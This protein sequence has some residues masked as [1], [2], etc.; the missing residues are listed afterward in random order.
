MKTYVDGAVKQG[1]AVID[2]NLPKHISDSDSDS[3][4]Y[5]E[6]D[7]VEARI[8]QATQLLTYLWENYIE[9]NENTHVFLLGTNT[10]HGAIVNFI[11]NHE[12]R[13]RQLITKAI[14]LVEDVGL[15]S[16]KSLVGN[17][18]LAQWYWTN[19]LVF[20]AQDHNYF[21]SDLARKPKKRFG[22]I[23][24]SQA[25]S[26]SDMLLEHREK[27]FESLLEETE[28]WRSNQTE[29]APTSLPNA[30]K[31]PPI[32]NFAL[33]PPRVVNAAL[34]VAS[35][36]DGNGSRSPAVPDHAPSPRQ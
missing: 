2:V 23:L 16:C 12:A 30:S 33:S 36:N 6:N 1:F 26:I 17:D 29:A 32:G 31:L 4:Q 11:K 24:Q 3:P 13:A 20:V 34:N 18:Q 28:E 9:L 8:K 35:G 10:G 19:S 21:A 15:M 7:S 5:Q 27:V 14:M 22:R 25:D